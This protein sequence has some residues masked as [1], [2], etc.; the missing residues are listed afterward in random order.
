MGGCAKG[1]HMLR[2]VLQAEH[3]LRL[4]NDR[5]LQR[6]LSFCQEG[7]PFL[8]SCEKPCIGRCARI[9]SLPDAEN[10]TQ[11]ASSDTGV[12][13][14]PGLRPVKQL[15]Q[16]L[17]V[18]HCL[19][20]PAAKPVLPV[21]QHQKG[22]LLQHAKAGERCQR[23]RFLPDMR[24][25]HFS[26]ADPSPNLGCGWKYPVFRTVMTAAQSLYRKRIDRAAAQAL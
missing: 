12:G 21:R 6:F 24:L 7:Q 9:F 23:K 25:L 11:D 16:R 2:S 14:T 5:D 20:D 13:K 26:A 15:R 22:F 1:E 3:F 17:T 4:R 8:I 19:P 10:R 18:A